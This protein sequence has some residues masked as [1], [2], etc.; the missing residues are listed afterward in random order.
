MKLK[1]Y[2]VFYTPERLAEFTADLLYEEARKT[3]T[4]IKTILDP[5]CGECALLY[6]A[7][8]RFGDEIKYFGIDVD[9]EAIVNAYCNFNIINNDS[10]LPKNVKKQT[11]EYWKRKMPKISAVIANPPWSSEKIYSHNELQDAGFSSAKGQ[12]DSYVLFIELAYNLLNE[13][14]YFAFILPDSLFDSQNEKLRKFLSEKMRIKVIARLGEKI[15]KEV[16]RSTTVIVCQKEKPIKGSITRCFRLTTEERKKFLSSESELLNIYNEGVHNV[17]QRRFTKNVAYN[18]DIDTR[19]DEEELLAKIREKNIT[20]NDT[21]IFGRGVEISKKGKIV[22]CPECGCAQGYKKE[23]FSNGEKICSNCGKKILIKEENITNV[24][25]KQYTPKT[26]TIFVGEN[27]RRYGITGE[28]YIEPDIPGINYKNRA[29]YCPPKLLVRKTGLGIYASIDYTGGMTSQTVYIL[30]FK[31]EKCGVPLEY[32]LALLNSRVVYYY[33]LKIY[34][35]NEW[36]SHPYF[37]KKI[38]FSLPIKEYE[39][40]ELDKQIIEL[41]SDLAHNYEHAKDIQLERLVM[42]KY[43]L[44]KNESSIIYKEMN[45]LPDLSAI[46]N[47]KIEVK[48][49][50]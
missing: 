46:N 14:G 8:K 49:D 22:L 26:I 20:W 1:K 45:R 44:S 5:A 16:S 18:F 7:N 24:I 36:K 33:Y 43:G 30:K 9:K 27:I 2:G 39:G 50:V 40:N 15:F 10:I 28:F 11:A 35:E 48:V 23:Q 12:Y 29:M 21:F 38:I 31:N 17:L 3:G 34:G 13:G 37:T 41:A 6:A 32:Y 4:V 47:M 25:S 19:T 42:K